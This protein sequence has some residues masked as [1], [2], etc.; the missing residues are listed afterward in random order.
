MRCPRCNTGFASWTSM[1]VHL[2]TCEG[3]QAG[4]SRVNRPHKCGRCGARFT[5]KYNLLVHYRRRHQQA[6]RTFACPFC[7]TFL[8]QSPST[9]QDHLSQRHGTQH[10]ATQQ[11]EVTVVPLT[12]NSLTL[13]TNFPDPL[14]NIR[15]LSD[16]MERTLRGQMLNR[17][18]RRV[19]FY[20]VLGGLF[21]RNGDYVAIPHRSTNRRVTLTTLGTLG[22]Q[23]S[24]ICSELE[25]R[26]Q[27]LQDL[28]GSAWRFLGYHNLQIHLINSPSIS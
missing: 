11:D 7:R 4:P 9:L 1:R 19:H 16:L 28:E 22:R 10:Q 20:A 26:A 14:F 3:P 18:F 6:E 24:M 17:A 25:E 12:E 23:W 8:C 15:D 27:S 5:R 13:T 21:E 2:R